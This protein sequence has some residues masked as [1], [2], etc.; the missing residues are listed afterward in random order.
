MY[1][2]REGHLLV[3]RHT[4]LTPEQAITFACAEQRKGYCTGQVVTLV[5]LGAEVEQY[6][7]AP[8]D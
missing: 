3:R 6:C 7:F 8:E 1:W 2:H 4:L 5:P